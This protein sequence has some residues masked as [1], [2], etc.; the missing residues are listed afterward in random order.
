MR[1]IPL[2]D[3]KTCNRCRVPQSL[4]EFNKS[5][6]TADGL[7]PTC[8]S[9]QRAYREASKDERR[10]YNRI[11]RQRRPEVQQQAQARYREANL[12]HVRAAGREYIR[13]ARQE[14]PNEF[15]QRDRARALKQNYGL[16]VEDYNERLTAQGGVCAICGKTE[17]G[18]LRVDHDHATGRVRGLL[19]NYCNVALGQV[20]DNIATL[21]NMISYLRSSEAQ[22]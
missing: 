21:E 22:S 9:C 11:Y 4:M 2:T 5:R 14:R 13:R 12:D 16:T 18:Y 6:A 7:Q 15:H 1:E 20:Q 17:K 8:R 3:G 10:E 19:C